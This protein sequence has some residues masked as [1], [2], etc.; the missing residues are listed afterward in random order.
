MF[1]HSLRRNVSQKL[2]RIGRE[3]LEKQGVRND[4]NV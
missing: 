3:M 2:R 1:P 4:R